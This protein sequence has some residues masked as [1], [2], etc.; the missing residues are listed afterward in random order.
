MTGQ[1]INRQSPA[2]GL[3]TA[4]RHLGLILTCATVA[5]A[6]G[7]VFV[8]I[9]AATYTATTQVLVYVKEVQPGAEL[10]ISLGR[11]DLTQVENEIEIIRSRGTLARVVNALNLTDDPEFVPEAAFVQTIVGLVFGPPSAMQSEERSRQDIAIASLVRRLAV[12]R[13]GTSHTIAIEVTSGD[14]ANSARIANGI[15]QAVLQARSAEQDGERAPLLRERL[16]GLGPSLYV[17]TPALT[18]DRPSGPRKL[19]VVLAAAILGLLT[20]AGLAIARDLLD[21]TVRTA[22][23]IERLGLECIGA[24]PVLPGKSDRARLPIANSEGRRPALAAL[25]NQTSLRVL[26]AAEAVQARV[27]GVASPTAGQGAAEVAWQVA[28][29]AARSHRKVVLVEPGTEGASCPVPDTAEPTSDL[30]VVAL[31]PLEDGAA[32]RIAAQDVDGV[33]LVVRS[34]STNFERIERAFSVAGVARSDF[35][36]AVLNEADERVLGRF[37]NTLWRAEALVASR[38][39]L[40][41]AKEPS[42][43][44]VRSA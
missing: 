18:P 16:R 19:L 12:R 25:L 38:R 8:G 22:R 40:F 29:V 21:R 2:L 17:M 4:R 15:S 34:G 5:I 7:L 31:P 11:A 24:F 41:A 27:I 30:I 3:F 37:G 14:A 36:G 32:F 10:V 28:Q 44:V 43:P 35:I 42:Q 13:I 20:G 6:A 23:Q 1:H 39:R 9:R 33:V 26:V